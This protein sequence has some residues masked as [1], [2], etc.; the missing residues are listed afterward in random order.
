[1]KATWMKAVMM[2]WRLLVVNRENEALNAEVFTLKHRLGKKANSI[3]DMNK[4]E[5]LEVA[6]KEIGL[7]ML[8]ADTWTVTVLREKI[9]K[10]RELT[11]VAVDPRAQLPK[12][13]N[14]MSLQELIAEVTVRELPLGEKPTRAQ[15]IIV[16]MDDVDQR[17]ILSATDP[18]AN[19]SSASN[20]GQEDWNM[21]SEETKKSRKG[22]K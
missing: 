9:K 20:T 13:L 16:I 19:T 3:W 17:N 5:L 15:L 21:V 10:V 18:T 2:A 11:K 6:R 4:L 8:Q 7:T 22:G 12:G 1:M 14:K